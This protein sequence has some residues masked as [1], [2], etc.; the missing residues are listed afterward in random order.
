MVWGACNAFSPSKCVT[1]TTSLGLSKPFLCCKVGF[2]NPRRIAAALAVGLAAGVFALAPRARGQQPAPTAQ[3]QSWHFVQT[4]TLDY[5]AILPPPPAPGSIAAE[6]DLMTVLHLQESRTPEQVAWARRAAAGDLFDFADV[7]GTW[8]S[9][10]NLPVT[11]KLL[12]DVD[13]DLDAAVVASKNAFPRPRPFLADP[14]IHPCVH[15]PGRNGRY[16]SSYPS[17]HTL[18]FYVEASVLARIFPDK[19]DALLDFAGRMAWGRVLGGVHFPTDLAGGR[20][21][22]AAIVTILEKNPAYLAAVGQARA[23]V[24]AYLAA[25]PRSP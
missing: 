24:A 8:F 4:G 14:R 3:V 9:K 1:T 21:A 13:D 11:A 15:R 19:R 5:S 10:A 23:E 7:L 6:A 16:D 22:A 2:M 12:A 17:G 20:L 25:Q 18:G